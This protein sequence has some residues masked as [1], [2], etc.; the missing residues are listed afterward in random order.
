MSCE[1]ICRPGV[2]S[3]FFMRTTFALLLAVCGI[4][5]PAAADV[6][7]KDFPVIALPPHQV[8][9]FSWGAGIRPMGDPCVLHIGVEPTNDN[10]WYVGGL[11]GLYMTKDA[12]QTWTHPL[13]GVVGALLVAQSSV[14]LVYAGIGHELYLSRDHGK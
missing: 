1:T 5:G 11:N 8:G 10:A 12:G 4:A 14:E 9:G 2:L 13:R 7:L 3:F 6:C